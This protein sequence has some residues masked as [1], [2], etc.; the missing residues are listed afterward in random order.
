MHGKFIFKNNAL[1]ENAG[2]V[3]FQNNV[4]HENASNVHIKNVPLENALNKLFRGMVILR[5]ML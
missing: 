3:H 5:T 2:N 4:P 1:Q